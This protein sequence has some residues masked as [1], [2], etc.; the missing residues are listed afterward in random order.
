MSTTPLAA[1]VAATGDYVPEHRCFG[2]HATMY[3]GVE[4]IPSLASV[5]VFTDDGSNQHASIDACGRERS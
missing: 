2:V 4:S 1:E 3:A 5:S